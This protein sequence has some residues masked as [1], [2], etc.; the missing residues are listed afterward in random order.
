MASGLITILFTDLVGSTELASEVGDVA[1]DELRRDHFASLREA[2]AATGGTEVK[3]IGDALDGV[4]PGRGRR[5]RRRGDDAARGRTP[6]P[7]ARRGPHR[8]CASASARATRASRTATG[9]A[10]RLSRRR[11]SARRRRGGQILVERSRARARRLAHRART[12]TAGRA[13]SSRASPNRSRPVRSS[14]HSPSSG[15]ASSRC[16]RSSTPIPR[17]RSRA[18]SSSSTA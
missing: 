11:G 10:R 4:V 18:G 17:S 13:W 1:A 3:T 2:V 5:A 9:S 6:Q 8:R 14:W 15:D 7:P 16:P 12:A